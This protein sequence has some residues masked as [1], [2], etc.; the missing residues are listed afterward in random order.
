MSNT[1]QGGAISLH[2]PGEP[3][4][5]TTEPTWK[6]CTYPSTTVLP[7]ST[8]MTYATSTVK[9]TTTTASQPSSTTGA[10]TTLSSSPTTIACAIPEGT[11][12]RIVFEDGSCKVQPAD[13]P[14]CQEDE[15]CWDCH[16]MGN[17]VCGTTTTSYP[18][19]TSIEPTQPWQ[20]S[21]THVVGT[22]PHTGSPTPAEAGVGAAFFG[23]GAV[24]LLAVGLSKAR[25]RWNS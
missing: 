10:P 18:L 19:D 20:T 25:S 13:V 23:V 11:P 14:Y 4:Y 21:T 24:M 7:S 8:T 3:G 15:P 1:M 22:L 17:H 16:T 5:T 2:C 6:H 12:G 9:A